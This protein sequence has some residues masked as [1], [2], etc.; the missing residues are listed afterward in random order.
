MTSGSTDRNTV[1]RSRRTFDSNEL[2]ASGAEL[3]VRV[4]SS[5]IRARNSAS[6][7]T[8]TAA[9]TPV[10]RQRPRPTADLMTRTDAINLVATLRGKGLTVVFTNGVFDLLHPGHLRYLDQARALGDALI[11]GVNSDRSVRGDKG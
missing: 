3:P 6:Q 2:V 11:V 7:A 4:L 10:R 9:R 5:A 1:G 8:V